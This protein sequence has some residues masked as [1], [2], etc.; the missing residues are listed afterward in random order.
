MYLLCTPRR[1]SLLHT[2]CSLLLLGYKP[3]QHGTVLNTVGNCN[4]VVSIL[5]LNIEKVQLK[6]DI[7]LWDQPLIPRGLSL[8]ETSLCGAWLYFAAWPKVPGHSLGKPE[9]LCRLPCFIKV[10]ISFSTL[11]CVPFAADRAGDLQCLLSQV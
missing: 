1:H 10:E 6:Q 4:T 8:F 3:V 7:I 11:H 5:Y 2:W 9:G